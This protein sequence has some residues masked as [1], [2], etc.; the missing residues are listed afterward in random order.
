MKGIQVKVGKIIKHEGQICRVRDRMH[1]TPGK[2]QAIV[3]VKMVNIITNS[4]VETRF[5]PDEDVEE[6]R[7][8]ERKMN[9]LYN[10]GDI[11]HFMDNETYEQTAIN[12][13]SLGD[14]V[15]YM[16]P[17]VVFTIQLYENKPVGVLPPITIDLKVVETDP[18]MKG[19]TVSGS[20]K[21]AVLE[22][23]VTIQVPQFIEVGEVIR[24]K[25]EENKYLER[26][27]K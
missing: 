11:Y 17:N 3:Q 5:R 24:V 10:E 14:A 15:N 20:M 21:P 4:N 26:A 13:D 27:K 12:K 23:G 8:D 1:I 25:P 16:I 22:T 7:L 19:A 2:G 18:H 9:Y 6:V